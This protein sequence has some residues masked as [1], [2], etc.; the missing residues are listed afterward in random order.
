[1]SYFWINSDANDC[2]LNCALY[3]LQRMKTRLRNLSRNFYLTIYYEIVVVK[4]NDC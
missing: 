1:M 3:G 2:E 4:S